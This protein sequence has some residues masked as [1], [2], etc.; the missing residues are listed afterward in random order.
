MVFSCSFHV[1]FLL[2][3]VGLSSD[4]LQDQSKSL[5]ENKLQ[6]ITEHTQFQNGHEAQNGHVV[7]N[8]HESSLEDESSHEAHSNT[9]S[10]Q[11]EHEVQEETRSNTES[12]SDSCAYETSD[13]KLE[14]VGSTTKDQTDE[15]RN[16]NE[17]CIGNQ[18][19][20]DNSKNINI[21]SMEDAVE[22][23]EIPK[24][25]KS[26]L[27]DDSSVTLDETTVGIASLELP[28][29]SDQEKIMAEEKN[30]EGIDTKREA[31][32][33]PSEETPSEETPSEE[34]PSEETVL[35]EPSEGG[36][37]SEESP[38]MKETPLND[39]EGGDVLRGGEGSSGRNENLTEVETKDGLVPNLPMEGSSIKEE[40]KT[41]LMEA[42]SSVD[43]SSAKEE[44][45]L[46]SME[47][48]VDVA[49]DKEIVETVVDVVTITED[50]E[51]IA[52][53]NENVNERKLSSPLKIGLQITNASQL[54]I[55]TVD[56][57]VTSDNDTPTSSSEG[58]L[59]KSDDC[60][61]LNDNSND[62]VSANRYKDRKSRTPD[63]PTLPKTEGTSKST[64]FVGSDQIDSNVQTRDDSP[65][66][67]RRG[68]S[69]SM[70]YNV[71]PPPEQDKTKFSTKLKR[72]F[73][74]TNKIKKEL[75][76]DGSV[77]LMAPQLATDWDPTCVLEELYSDCRPV[78]PQSSSGE[79]CRYAGYMD[80][81]PVNQSK[82]TVM[83]G[84]RHR[85]FR[86]TRG[87][88]FYY[89]DSK[90]QKA[91]S[92]VRL[93][94]AKIV[95]HQEMLK[96]E[97][98]EKNGNSILLRAETKEE[99]VAFNRALQLE[100]VHPTLT[101]RLSLSPTRA[102]PTIILDL[103]SCSIRAGLIS[104]DNYP[105]V[106]FPNVCAF[107]NETLVA[108]GNDSLL[109]TT[110]GSSKLVYPRRHRS[111]M[112][113]TVSIRECFTA[114]IE[115]ICK[116]LDA[117]PEKCNVLV[118]ISP[119]MPEMEQQIL[120]EVVLETLGFQGLLLQEQTTLALYSYNSTTGVSVNVGDSISIVPIIDGYKVEGADNHTPLGGI[121]VTEN[122]SKLASARDIRYFSDTEMYIIR[123]V[124]E[125]LCF[126]SQ[127]Y[128]EDADKCDLTPHEYTRAVDVDRFQLPDH[129]KVIALDLA[130]FKA[131]EG[132]FQPAIW[133]KDV[134]GIHDMIH[135]SIEQCPLDMKREMCRHVYLSGGTSLM[136]GFPE[137][138]KMELGKLFPRMEIVVH[139][140]ENR[141]H[142]AYLG[143]CI[144]AS[145]SSFQKS[146]VTQDDWISD[147]FS[148]FRRN[149]DNANAS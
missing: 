44:K 58:I 68:K 43:D 20:H 117:K 104:D 105:Q 91:I 94:D 19:I 4:T 66:I 33:I 139:A 106:F 51:E 50:K 133:G 111:R 141:Y 88:M 112:D 135:R 59:S 102:T 24:D 77:S 80:K 122:L 8:G 140:D 55:K 116:R 124:K 85:Y 97:I 6:I 148:A 30:D 29:A 98:T 134:L 16:E 39:D 118:S 1:P 27:I 25:N 18:S 72:S 137:R 107:S 99:A 40:V 46:L 38:S 130:L 126:L 65:K 145:L 95:L 60:H 67:A 5:N 115:A 22:K 110:R 34:T 86:V 70:F 49:E 108:C 84:W 28:E 62:R 63:P 31:P 23:Q 81:L 47:S 45:V 53:S 96:V 119:I 123:H 56:D 125:T 36:D 142:A 15:T 61:I 147:G 69:L 132:L 120:A 32:E 146:L 114:I 128:F 90:S 42:E 37:P 144:L 41:P 93:T 92:F 78:V 73:K 21:P 52:E 113:S 100:S 82:P 143:A 35:K 57:P 11:N 54:F 2:I 101:H 103:G 75:S 13:T 12:Q 131:P 17:S 71:S 9:E 76:T 149:S 83:K 79:N 109:P 26:A 7:Q 89:D 129:K 3:F 10:T 138:L 64:F 48:E 136:A 87:S 127:E 74:R 14:P 121:N